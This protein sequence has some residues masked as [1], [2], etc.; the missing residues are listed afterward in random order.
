M[1]SAGRVKKRQTPLE[2]CAAALEINGKPIRV[3]WT[4]NQRTIF[5]TH[6]RPGYTEFRAHEIYK[7]ANAKLARRILTEIFKAKKPVPQRAA[8]KIAPPDAE[9]VVATAFGRVTKVPDSGVRVVYEASSRS[10]YLRATDVIHK[11]EAL[12]YFNERGTYLPRSRNK[13]P[14]E[15]LELRGY[16]RS[17]TMIAD[18]DPDDWGESYMMTMTWYRVDGE[19]K[20]HR[21]E[22]EQFDDNLRSY[23]YGPDEMMGYSGAV[24]L[25][26]EKWGAV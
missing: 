13:R 5:S 10:F 1:A 6:S 11:S 25:L 26:L 23:P 22:L 8:S 9:D 18:D 20:V 16:G 17:G 12:V 15:I 21:E 4:G 19:G 14:R 7:D 3:V 24:N 2:E